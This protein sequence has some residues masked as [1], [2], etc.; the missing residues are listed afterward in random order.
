VSEP[1][2]PQTSTSETTANPAS[3]AA[4]PHCGQPVSFVASLTAQRLAC[5]HCGGEFVAPAPDG[6]TDLPDAEADEPS[7][8]TDVPEDELSAIRIRQIAAGRRASYRARS[9]CIIAATV[10]LVATAELISIIVRQYR[11]A[12]WGL[13]CTG[14]LLFTFLALYG[15]GYF[16][17]RA[18]RMHREATRSSLAEPALAP[19][20]STLDN[21]SKR[22][23]NLEDVR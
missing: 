7:E 2:T 9:Y 3:D 20:F 21:G 1:P 17:V 15:V 6:S 18:V 13:Q 4:C 8:S 5:P 16:T 12:G 22:V 23:Q 10:C 19:D 11:L 14:Y